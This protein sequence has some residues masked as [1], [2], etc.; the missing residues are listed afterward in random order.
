MLA[1]PPLHGTSCCSRDSG[2]TKKRVP[3]WS[4]SQVCSS[5][6]AVQPSSKASRKQMQ[7]TLPCKKNLGTMIL[8]LPKPSALYNTP[9][10]VLAVAFR[11]FQK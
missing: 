7:R 2:A 4:L 6:P 9:R 3:N 11:Q 10:E 8:L 5:S 1:E